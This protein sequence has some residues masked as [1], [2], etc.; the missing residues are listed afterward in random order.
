M[1][2]QQQ[3]APV[4]SAPPPASRRRAWIKFGLISTCC[5][6][7]NTGLFFADHL[8]RQWYVVLSVD[9]VILCLIHVLTT[10]SRAINDMKAYRADLRHMVVERFQHTDDAQR[11]FLVALEHDRYRW[12]LVQ[13]W[14]SLV[15]VA[16]SVCL[17]TGALLMNWP[18][19][20]LLGAVGSTVSTIWWT[21]VC[22]E[23]ADRTIEQ[24]LK[25][26]RDQLR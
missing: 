3:H 18:A 26:L 14:V 15:L 16:G 8:P 23:L 5:F 2:Q 10:P 17:T 22:Y 24:T 11:Y 19:F 7:A 25:E 1:P 6:V 12:G 13:Y 4:P 21:I 9:L 20:V